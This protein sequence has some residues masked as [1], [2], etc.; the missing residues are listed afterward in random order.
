MSIQVAIR[1]QMHYDYD[2]YIEVSPQIIRLK[3]AAHSRTRVEAYS[4][5]IHPENHFINWHQDPFGNYV[6]RIVFPQKINHL[7]VDVEV[8]A[9]M[10]VINPF[11]FFLDTYAETMP[12][13]YE[14]QLKKE[15]LPYFEKTESSPS[16]LQVVGEAKQRLNKRTIDFL[17]EL[18]QSI[19]HK[20]GY[21]IRMEPGVQTCDETLE[22]KSGS[23]RDSAWLLV[24]VLRHIGLASRFVSGY[25]IQLKPDD[26]PIEG[27][28]GP[29][30][31]FTDL[32][33][34]AEVYIPGAGWIGLDPT[35]G[36]FA[37]E[38]HI[39]LTCTPHPMSAA[40]ITG[41]IEVCETK[42][43]FKNE[44]TRIY[45]KP[46]TSQ[47]VTDQQW[48]QI[49]QLAE[50]IDSDL[51]YMDVRLT[52]GGEP[53]FVSADDLDSAEWNSAADGPHKRKLAYQLT[54]N[55]YEAYGGNGLIHFGQGKQYPGEPLPRWQYGIFRRKDGHPIWRH[56]ELFAPFDQS[57]H[58]T[59]KELYAL[60]DK[61]LEILRLDQNAMIPAY[62]DAFYFAWE[63][64]K[65]P[66]DKDPLQYKLDDPIERKTLT[67]VLN[68]GLANPKGYVIPLNQNR[69]TQE[70]DTC[71]WQLKRNHLF[72]IPGNSPIGYR[73]PLN[74]IPVT[75]LI[76]NEYDR[77]PF[78]TIGQLVDFEKRLSGKPVDR[79]PI[80]KDI[81]FRTALC[82]EVVNGNAYVFMPP[83]KRIEA[84]LE[85]VAAIQ[86]A[87][88]ALSI[89]VLIG[90]YE[91]PYDAKIE[92]LLVTPD[93]GVIEVNIS[94]SKNWNQLSETIFTLYDVAKSA[95]LSSEK[96]MVDGR[97]T[98]TGGGN[99]ITLGG[100]VPS[101]SPFIRKPSLIRSMITF[102]QHH[103]SLSYLFSGTFIGPTSQAPR[104]DEGREDALYELDLAFS[105]IPDTMDPPYWLVDRILRN[106][107]IDVTGNTHR[108]EFCIDKL[109]SPFGNTGR[110]GLVEFRGFEMPPHARMCALQYLLIRALV[111]SFWKNQYH[112]K[113]I[114]WGR[115]LHD[116][117]MLEHFIRNDFHQVILFLQ[118]SGYDFEPSWFDAYFEFKF[119]ILGILQLN[120]IGLELRW[121]L[122]PWHVLGEEVTSQGTARYV[123][124]SVERVQVKLMGWH[125]D[126]YSLSC[127]GT[128][129]PVKATSQK[130]VFV[131]GIRYKAWSPPS[132][133]HPT[134][135]VDTPLTLDIIDT[136]NN[137]SIGGCTYFV[138][139]PGGRNYE[140]T[141]V[142][143]LEAEARRQARFYS[144]G[145]TAGSLTLKQE[146]NNFIGRMFNASNEIKDF[147]I[148]AMEA[149]LDLGT[150][151]DLRKRKRK[152]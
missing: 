38:G 107:L 9:E 126:R 127:N 148:P 66:N 30:T 137:K 13:E 54:K 4:L 83:Q 1:H 20:I 149:D 2:R 90:G 8:I 63:E 39:P 98:G 102:W 80:R 109:Y 44:V 129:I 33:A 69:E 131:A 48:I 91:T 99:H 87:A 42:F 104:V 75:N 133:L 45:E 111:S 60:G 15:L 18:N 34:W 132:A 108:S 138:A 101:D 65:L 52:M 40:P 37:G 144:E 128:I 17:V 64:Y 122:E 71:T 142:N 21:T 31:D 89:P 123:D 68:H 117:F 152:A 95:R 23:C 103:P 110:L 5:K 7:Y 25:L 88:K 70:W 27:P 93:P 100:I 112:K 146:S 82:L 105:Q 72:L 147:V 62:E 143:A 139:H 124:S 106:L 22:R 86:L 125:P 145:H 114:Y 32:H 50:R 141:P 76:E 73:L 55:L 26:K 140:I 116:K 151:F 94:P 3:P 28:S 81:T 24:Q 35:S 10:V 130:G 6:A 14:E 58:L 57:G 53:T 74:S 79:K 59:V 134:I 43:S 97:H 46:R 12:F 56:K 85:L 92:K 29:S 113:L 120:E 61:I 51:D 84:Y 77:D 96:F 11:D 136:W 118:Q 78:S 135:G 41:M 67:E 16:L 47:P 150:T 19:Y 115:E 121:A 49:N 119:P 36:L